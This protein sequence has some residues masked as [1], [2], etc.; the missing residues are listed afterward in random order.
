MKLLRS[1][2]MMRK[3]S[4]TIN[5]AMQTHS[6]K[7]ATTAADLI[8]AILDSAIL[9]ALILVI[10]LTVFSQEEDSMAVK[11]VHAADPASEL[12]WRLPLRRLQRARPSR[13]GF[14]G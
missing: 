9:L 7:P 3:G 4:S 2:A 8:S 13:F 10:S 1:L 14:P 12:M 6:E 11:K 5:S